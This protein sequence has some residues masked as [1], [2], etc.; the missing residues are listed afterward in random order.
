MFYEELFGLEKAHLIFEFNGITN[1]MFVPFYNRNLVNNEVKVTLGD[2]IPTQ[3]IPM[4]LKIEIIKLENERFLLKVNGRLDEDIVGHN[5]FYAHLRDIYKIPMYEPL[6]L[7]LSVS[8][9]YVFREGNAHYESFLLKK[10]MKENHN[11]KEYIDYGY[12]I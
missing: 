6:N 9:Y 8:G 5:K 3:Y 2:L 12:K 4:V 10:T 1:S 11:L 7:A